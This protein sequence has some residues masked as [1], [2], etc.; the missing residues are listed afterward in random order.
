MNMLCEHDQSA[1]SDRIV[2]T[3]GFDGKGFL[4]CDR[5]VMTVETQLTA[6]EVK[7]ATTKAIESDDGTVEYIEV[8]KSIEPRQS[9][10][11]ALG[12]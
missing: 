6:E 9:D 5:Y 7:H 8:L 10:S 12:I 2:S 3:F 4:V 1:Q 11:L